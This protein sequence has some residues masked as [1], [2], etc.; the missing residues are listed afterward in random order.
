MRL[1]FLLFV[2]IV[3]SVLA[4]AGENSIVPPGP[5]PGFIETESSD[6][7]TTCSQLISNSD[8]ENDSSSDNPVVPAGS[9]AFSFSG[10]NCFSVDWL[11][12]GNPLR[13]LDH[14]I[15]FSDDAVMSPRDSVYFI[16][17]DDGS[18]LLGIELDSENETTW[19]CYACAGI[20]VGDWQDNTLYFTENMGITWNTFGNPAGSEGRGM[21]MD[22][23]T[24]TVWETHG[25]TTLYAFDHSSPVG[26]AYDVSSVIA[27]QM[28]GLA[29]Y[30][31]GDDNWLLVNTYNSDCS[32]IFDL[33]D[34]LNFLGTAAFPYSSNFSKSYG[35]TYTDTRDT[36]LWS[37]KDNS[38]NCYLVELELEISALE[39]TTWGTIKSIF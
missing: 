23:Y 39:Q 26:T 17:L 28:S 29:V 38:D 27:D 3:T 19:G 37:Y 30:N 22:Y 2:L 5:E 24:F 36:F 16:S 18:K 6:I 21:D 9:R 13:G 31:N 34:S 32:Y 4:F 33:D 14:V 1:N 10:L 7:T 20:A 25:S 35:L 15:F 12:A 8:G 11:G